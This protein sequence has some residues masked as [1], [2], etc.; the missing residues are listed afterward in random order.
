MPADF[1]GSKVAKGDGNDSTK[2][3]TFVDAAQA[4]VNAI[5][6]T[7]QSGFASGLVL[8]PS[9][10]KQNA[11]T[12]GQ[13]LAWDGT[14]W[15]PAAAP[16]ATA[17]TLITDTSISAPTASFDFTSISGSFKHLLLIG[18]ARSDRAANTEDGCAVQFNND[19][20]GNY[21]SYGVDVSGTTPTLSVSENLAATFITM[22]KLLPAATAGTNLFGSF[23]LWVPNYANTT[24]NKIAHW[25]LGH[26]IGT[27]TGN[28][29][30]NDGFGAWR[31][32]TAISRV[33]LK[34]ANGANF[35]SGSRVVLYGIN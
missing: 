30:V 14:K 27:S 18:Y 15:A 4:A 35:V 20:A 25:V 1:S 7:S 17:F 13:L 2:F 5:G 29:T 8:D 23:E 19:T 34:S 24:A 10:L 6:D 33:T 12:S 22:N 16:P 26:K 3:D 28:I 11:A 9:K 21:D 32:N 31:S